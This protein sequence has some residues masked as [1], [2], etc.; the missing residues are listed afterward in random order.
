M[1]ARG[2]RTK[3]VSIRAP[4]RGA[5]RRHRHQ[6][7]ASGRFDPRSRAGSDG[8]R[9]DG[10]VPALV[11]I[12]APARGATPIPRVS[13]VVG[14]V[15]IRA[16]ARGATPASGARSCLGTVS[17]RA[18]ARGATLIQGYLQRFYSFRSALPR[19]ERPSTGSTIAAPTSFDPRSRAGSDAACDALQALLL[20]V[21]IR[22]P[23]RGAT[24]STGARAILAEVSIRAPARGATKRWTSPTPPRTC[25]DP[26]SRAGSDHPDRRR[27]EDVG[28]VSIRAP[29]RG[30][31]VLQ[32]LGEDED[33]LFRSALPRGERQQ[34]AHMF[35]N[36]L[37][38]RSALPRGERLQ[39]DR[40]G[41][42]SGVVSIRAPARGAT[43]PLRQA[44]RLRVGVSI[45]APA[46][47]A[48]CRQSQAARWR[49][50]FDPRSRAGS[51]LAL[52]RRPGLAWTRCRFDPRSRAGSDDREQRRLGG[53]SIRAP[54]RGATTW[55]SPAPCATGRFDP[56]SRAGSDWAVAEVA[57]CSMPVVSIRAPARGATTGLS[58]AHPHERVSIRAPAR[59]ATTGLTPLSCACFSFDPRS[60]AGS[61]GARPQ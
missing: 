32:K 16:P 57:K 45:R 20:E 43:R 34:H 17:I 12:R 40:E 27:A 47:G 26:R 53:V 58:G 19:G 44:G 31:T 7:Q 18:P 52:K 29:A 55:P 51:D 13:R 35:T 48:T 21:S 49:S 24:R 39:K 50:R 11:S 61:D 15:S 46:R 59:G 30:A 22:A 36:T 33:V 5:T 38:F 6:G 3:R 42:V 25:F 1:S 14:L 54:A 41:L 10:A 60:R 8:T 37:M 4:A 9:A 23:A 56:R 28:A 2:R